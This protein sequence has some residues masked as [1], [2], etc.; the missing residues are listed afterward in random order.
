MTVQ[1]IRGSCRHALGKIVQTVVCLSCVKIVPL[2]FKLKLLRAKEVLSTE[3]VGETQQ[4]SCCL[5]R[6][7]ADAQ[8]SASC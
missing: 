2:L 4:F 7:T 8:Q 5:A 1:I 6:H 3:Q